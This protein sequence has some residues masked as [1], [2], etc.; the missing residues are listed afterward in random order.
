MSATRMTIA[1]LTLLAGALGPAGAVKAWEVPL[2]VENSMRTGAPP[3]ISG[4]VPLLPGQAKETSDLRLV[5]KDGTGKTTA[6]PAQFRVLARYWRGDN[7]IR[8]VLVDFA[9][10]GVPGEKKVVFLTDTQ[11][12]PAAG[13]PQAKADESPDTIVVSTGVA[14]F[15]INRKR[16]N[17]LQGAVVDGVELIDNSADAGTVIEDILGGKYY[18]TEGTTSVDVL[19]NGP[20]RV[21]VRAR[22]RHL[23]RDGQGY[24][25]GMYGFDVFLNF[26]A[27][28]SD[29]GLDVVVTNNFATS[30]GEPLMKDASLLLKLAG[31]AAGCRVHGAAPLDSRLRADASL[32]LYQ[33]S[34]GAETWQSCTGGM[35][36][37]TRFRG[38]RVLRRSEGKEDLVTQGDQARGLMHVFN[39]R[40]GIVLMMR[41]FW[42]QFPKAVEAGGDGTLRLGL[43]PRECAVPQY[44]DDCSAKG[45]EVM[46]HFYAKGKSRYASD[47][48]GRTW[49]HVVADQWDLAA[50]PR[51]TIEHIAAAGALSDVGPFTPPVTGLADYDVQMNLRRILM[52]DAIWGNCLGWQ[53][54][55]ERWKSWGGHS[56]RGARQPIE[57]DH[58]LRSYYWTG[59]P[60]W[61]DAGINRSRQFRDVRAYRIDGQDALGFKDWGQFRKNNTSEGREWTSRPIPDDEELKKYQAGLVPHRRWEFPNP[62]HCTLD[63][64]YDRYLLFGDVRSLESMRAAAGHGAFYALG[65][66]PKP[67][68]AKVGGSLGRANGWS[69]RTLERYWEL[70][71]D[72]RADELVK[73]VI[74]AYQPLIGKAPL[75]FADNELT[76]A[77]DWFT[78]IC[79]R[80]AAMTALHTA[81]PKALEICKALA[82]GKDK[83]MPGSVTYGRQSPLSPGYFSTLFA[84]LYHLTGQEHYRDV[85]I[86]PGGGQRLLTAGGGSY[87][88]PSDHWLLTQPP[89]AGK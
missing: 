72:P 36:P 25:R 65:Y 4:G 2:T 44:L 85:V 32:C 35:G 43:F 84:V 61:L 59:G 56:T 73:E 21:C 51:P 74:A 11:A 10:A 71:G 33:D 14:R 17:L 28:S 86:K 49:P 37:I 76:H 9:A 64:I 87:F 60:G 18:A 42:Q 83:P 81:D 6:I 38:Y 22:G 15:T 40:G 24:S 68:A 50:L 30:I 75:W 89:K 7:S 45:H 29:V 46:L 47:P 39:D 5:V 54:Y 55:G 13:K 1:M 52:T 88:L 77:S 57:E 3:F 53:M 80:A 41:N 67:G 70:T 27:A 69:W 20:V 19:E 78:Q 66:A 23:A 31:G 79:T 58:F 63:L 82:E 62:E 34:N 8:W 48:E 16:F 12:E 26:Y